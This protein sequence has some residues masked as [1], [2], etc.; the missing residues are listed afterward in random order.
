M[1]TA[2]EVVRRYYR[3]AGDLRSTEEELAALL[4]PDVRIVEHPNPITPRGAVRDRAQTLEGYRASRGLLREQRFEVLEAL[5]RD[6][7]VAVRARWRAR[8]GVSRGP[9]AAGTEMEAHVASFLT[10]EEGRTAVQPG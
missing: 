3:V 2:L 9:L 10:V 5:E 7:R 4:H 6:G 1:S 8:T